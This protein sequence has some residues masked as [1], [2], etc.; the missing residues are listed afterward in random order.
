[1]TRPPGRLQKVLGSDAPSAQ[2]AWA[3]LRLGNIQETQAIQLL[4]QAE[5]TYRQATGVFDKL[6]EPQTMGRRWGD[7]H[8]DDLKDTSTQ[9]QVALGQLVEF[10]RIMPIHWPGPS[11]AASLPSADVGKVKI[12]GQVGKPDGEKDGKTHQAKGKDNKE[13]VELAVEKDGKVEVTVAGKKVELDPATQ[14]QILKHL[15]YALR[16]AGQASREA[17]EPKAQKTDE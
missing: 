15:Q 16:V 17:A 4:G 5:Q 9:L 12:S 2:R 8:A 14:R 3:F 7:S 6:A 13:T 10:N 11:Q 1:M